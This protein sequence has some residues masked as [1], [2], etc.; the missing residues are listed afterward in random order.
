MEE[1]IIKRNYEKNF[2]KYLWNQY[3]SLHERLTRKI[4]SL[5]KILS[6][7]NDIYH[8]KKEYYKNLKP[9]IKDEPQPLIEEEN[10]K[11]TMIIVKNNNEKYIEFEDEMYSEIIDKIRSLIEKMKQEK[12]LYDDFKKA[13]DYYNGEKAKMEKFKNIYHTNGKIAERS[14][15]YYK[16]LQIKRKIND[17]NIMN[18][19][20]DKSKI[21][22]KNRLIGLS[23]DCSNYIQSLKNVN[24]IRKEVNKKQD[25]L[26]SVY[27]ELEWDDK[28]LYADVMEIIWKYQKKVYDYTGKQ[29]NEV[30]IIQNAIHI[31]KDIR[32]LVEK[33]RKYESPEEEI[34]YEHYPTEV[35]FDKCQDIKDYRVCDAIVKEMKSYVEGIFENYDEKLED[36]KNRFRDLIIKFFDK[37]RQT[38]EDDKKQ[39]LEFVEDTRTH[40]IFLIVLAKLRTN[41]RFC[42][43]RF[44]IELLSDIMLKLLDN[45]QKIND[46]SIA[47]NCLI[48]SQ[49]FFFYDENDKNKKIYISNYIKKHPWL[50]SPRFWGDFILRQ[51]LSEFNK[52]E[53]RNKGIERMIISL[54]KC[55][56]ENM[57]PRIGEVLFSQLLP[58]VGNMNEVEVDKKV[59][60]KIVDSILEKFP[61][62][63]ETNKVEIYK[64]IC[65][66]EEVPKFKEQIQ[67]D[68]SL[69]NF[70]LDINIVK[71]FNKGKKFIDAD[72]YD[73]F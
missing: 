31:D 39:L 73:D 36:K 69:K 51:I 70:S 40:G 54:R 9:L 13:L 56:P 64:M 43:D 1:K 2:R 20:I 8:V 29:L 63:E 27:Q 57:K 3:D 21:D 66:A 17:Q 6:S 62:I 10:F 41:N 52:V 37:N 65:A 22:C 48:L 28:N 60:I 23:K 47:K 35:D 4:G 55:V 49:T 58:Y 19:S 11:Q 5:S 50:Q 68:E 59:T 44:L 33:L 16:D 24:K 32:G 61:F 25:N 38:T 45:A 72:D 15:L 12:F 26:L 34:L 46:F 42:R 67:N 30:E 53:E 18:Q 71:E 14:T 7:F